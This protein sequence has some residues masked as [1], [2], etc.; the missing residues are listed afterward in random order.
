MSKT[1][2]EEKHICRPD[3]HLAVLSLTVSVNRSKLTA[4]KASRS[5]AVKGRI[6]IFVLFYFFLE[7]KR[8]GVEVEVLQNEGGGRCGPQLVLCR[9]APRNAAATGPLSQGWGRR[10]CCV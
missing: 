1:K 5:S 7:A 2:G 4:A 3:L 10:S 6:F 9:R 8:R